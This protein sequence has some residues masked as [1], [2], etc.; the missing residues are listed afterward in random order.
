[1][2]DFFGWC[3]RHEIGPLIDI[4]PVHI[5]AWVEE[6]GRNVSAPTVKQNLAAVRHLFDWL[7]ESSREGSE[8]GAF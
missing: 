8:V 6:R 1:M 4:E 5:A 7:V 2:A 3:E